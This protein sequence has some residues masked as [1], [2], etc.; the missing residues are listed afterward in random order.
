MAGMQ[1]RAVGFV[2]VWFSEIQFTTNRPQ[3]HPVFRSSAPTLQDPEE[4]AQPRH[5]RG[6]VVVSLRLPDQRDRTGEPAVRRLANKHPPP[7]EAVT[8]TRKS[9]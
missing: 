9:G 8:Q 7:L 3:D 1:Y 6:N 2:L 4:N 5:R